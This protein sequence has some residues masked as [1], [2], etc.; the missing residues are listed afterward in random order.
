[1]SSFIFVRC[2]CGAQLKI[3]A[4]AGIETRTLK[5]PVCQQSYPFASLERVAAPAPAPA[6]EDATQDSD[7][8]GSTVGRLV[9]VGGAHPVALREG[10]NIVGRKAQSSKSTVQLPTADR[11]MHREQVRIE[12]SRAASGVC[13]HTLGVLPG[14]GGTALNGHAI[15]PGDVY[16]LADGDV[17]RMGHTDVRFELP[18]AAALGHRKTPASPDDT[19]LA[20]Y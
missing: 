19:E 16:V 3:P 4:V 1:M 14:K 15:E 9:V 11:T 8:V 20:I 18:A 2:K 10:K 6:D 12:V 17:I 5:C 7:D 13:I